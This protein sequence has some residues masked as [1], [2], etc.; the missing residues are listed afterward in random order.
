M[1]TLTGIYRGIYVFFQSPLL[2][3]IVIAAGIFWHMENAKQ[4]AI[5]AGQS[6]GQANAFKIIISA[7]VLILVGAK[8]EV[9]A[10]LAIAL[11]A[12]I[13]C[14][15]VYI[16]FQNIAMNLPQWK[17]QLE[18]I[19]NMQR[20]TD[21]K[22]ELLRKI[23]QAEIENSRSR[24]IAMVFIALVIPLFMGALSHVF[25]QSLSQIVNSGQ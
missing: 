23:E 25:I 9:L 15:L 8:Q 19:E 5:K 21:E 16:F 3:V 13:N 18:L 11:E 4:L 1:E 2:L 7:S 10:Y 17:K 22:L 6:K 20:K 24:K 12:T 14:I